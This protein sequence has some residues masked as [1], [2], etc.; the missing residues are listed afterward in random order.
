MHSNMKAV[1]LAGGYGT[2][3][4]EESSIK[5]KPIVEIGGKP[6]LWHIM[7]IY[8]HYNVKD[9]II[10]CGYKGYLIK[11]YFSSYL[12]NNSDFTISLKEN[13]INIHKNPTENWNITL[14][15]T[16]EKTMTG[17]RL[18]RVRRYLKKGE[19]FF[20]T[21]GDGVSNININK[22]LAFH[23]KHK[24]KATVT[25]VQPSGRYGSVNFDPKSNIVKNFIEKPKGDKNWIN[26]GFF[27]LNESVIDFIKGDKEIWEKKPLENLSKKKQLMAFKHEGFWK[28]M[29]TLNDRN[30]LE[31]MI[32]KNDA[33]WVLW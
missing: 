22:L 9:F 16:G 1:I 11:E 25:V 10:C 23:K 17:G 20:L 32:A 33:P 7:K 13:N 24:K 30:Q 18:K 15:D 19:D 3:I 27:V 12:I 21:Y 28:A 2:R 6:V 14:I 26:G 5:P 8:S 4:S 31:S 29:D